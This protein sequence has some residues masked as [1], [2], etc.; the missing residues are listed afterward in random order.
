VASSLVTASV[1]IADQANLYRKGIISEQ[2]FIENSELLSLDVS[3]S[4]LSSLLGQV[5]I[6]IPVLGAVIGNTVGTVIYKVAKDGLDDKEQEIFK[7]YIDSIDATEIELN[8][9]Y[10][11][12]KDTLAKDMDRYMDILNLTYSA[13][14]VKVFNGSVE[15][16]KYM[17]VPSNEILDSK[18]K[19]DS[20]FIG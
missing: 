7:S 11:R 19:I 8:E 9:K 15:M 6:P 18:E 14:V 2:Q 13:D 10:K 17:G 16:A 1:G 20:Y 12:C 3:V 4:A 5:I